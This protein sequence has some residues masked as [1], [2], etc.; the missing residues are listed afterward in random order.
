MRRRTFGNLFP[1][2]AFET[3]LRGRRM[4][5][6]NSVTFSCKSTRRWRT[7]IVKL[8]LLVSLIGLYWFSS[9]N[10]VH[11][12]TKFKFFLELCSFSFQPAKPP[13]L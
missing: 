9:V 3:V 11:T 12:R 8:L 13:M 10:F 4:S 6:A 5:F 7:V 2:M 1:V